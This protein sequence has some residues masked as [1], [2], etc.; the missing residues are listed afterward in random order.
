MDLSISL[1]F[2]VIDQCLLWVNLRSSQ[3]CSECRL[4]GDKRTSNLGDWM[5]A[6]SQK[7]K[8]V[9]FLRRRFVIANSR[10]IPVHILAGIF[11][12]LLVLTVPTTIGSFDN[13]GWRE[14]NDRVRA[15]E[16]WR[17]LDASTI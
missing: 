9:I 13:S 15:M 14:L 2:T 3:P 17:E 8:F 11:P 5:S 6:F 4:L 12:G 1:R 16:S 7:R 10:P